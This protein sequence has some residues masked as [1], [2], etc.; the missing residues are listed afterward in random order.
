MKVNVSLLMS[1]L[2]MVLIY[3]VV[4]ATKHQTIAI[5]SDKRSRKFGKILFA[6]NNFLLLFLIVKIRSKLV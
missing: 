6:L 4:F 5:E 3:L 1:T 2:L